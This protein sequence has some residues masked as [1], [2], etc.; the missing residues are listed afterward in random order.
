LIF[1][2]RADAGRR[3][4]EKLKE[5]AGEDGVVLAIP[6]GGVVV[7]G[8]VARILGLKLD[9][10]IPR[11]LGAPHNPEVAIGA[12]AQDGTT[13]FDRRLLELLGVSQAELEEII[14][15]EINEIKRRLEIYRGS[16]DQPEYAGRQLVVVDDGV[17]TGYTM[18][19]ALRSARN[20]QPRELILAIPVAPRDTLE[21]LE[22]EVDRAVCLVIPE[23]FYAVGQFYQRFDQTEDC[24]V[25]K[26]LKD[27]N[28]K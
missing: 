17:A 23:D 8:E 18:Q 16:G 13:I 3:L 22:K 4:A 14:S 21:R 11:K 12:V 1:S 6:R 2:D 25:V 15:C 5:Y 9:L 19:A 27:F 28:K 24:E 10:I 20:F 7:G 26:I